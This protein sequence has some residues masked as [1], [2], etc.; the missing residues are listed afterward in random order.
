MEHKVTTNQPAPKHTPLRS[1]ILWAMCLAIAGAMG[2]A[3][4]G[5]GSGSGSGNP[6]TVD[7]LPDWI[8]TTGN[9]MCIVIGVLVLLPRTR[10]VG[11]VLAALMMLAS[12]A[13]NYWVD[14]AAYFVKVLPFNMITLALAIAVVWHDQGSRHDH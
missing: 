7:P 13:A 1:R 11:A 2:L 5:S 14:G 8:N 4:S 9:L 12:M 3:G 10:F 6:A